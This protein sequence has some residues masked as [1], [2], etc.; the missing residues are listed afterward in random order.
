MNRKKKQ[1]DEQ[2]GRRQKKKRSHAWDH[3]SK[4]LVVCSSKPKNFQEVAEVVVIIATM[5]WNMRT[6]QLCGRGS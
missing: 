2:P 1:M 5:K 3:F 6:G 4:V